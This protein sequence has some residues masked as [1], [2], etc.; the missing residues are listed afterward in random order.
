MMAVCLALKTFLLALKG[1]HVLVRLDNTTVV[2][3]INHQGRLKFP[4]QDDSAGHPQSVQ[5]IWSVFCKAE[6][7]TI[8]GLMIN[9]T[10][11]PRG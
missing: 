8:T 7:I 6:D 1:Q 10:K 2:D 4:L 9:H 3:Y 5:M 11:I